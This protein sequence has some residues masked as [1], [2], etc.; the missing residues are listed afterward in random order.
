[1]RDGYFPFNGFSGSVALE[2]A[3][4]NISSSTPGN[5]VIGG[6]SFSQPFAVLA[7]LLGTRM[8]V[9]NTNDRNGPGMLQVLTMNQATAQM[10]QSDL[11]FIGDTSVNAFVQGPGEQFIYSGGVDCGRN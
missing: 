10:Q 3:T 7:D 5:T 2:A 8:L 11:W 9:L 1:P 6:G 4:G